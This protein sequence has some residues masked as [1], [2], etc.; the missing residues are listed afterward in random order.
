MSGAEFI[1]ESPVR[2]SQIKAIRTL[3]QGGW[4][5]LHDL[6]QYRVSGKPALGVGGLNPGQLFQPFLQVG[7]GPLRIGF[8]AQERY[9]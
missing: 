3:D 1:Q 8:L 9:R 4:H 7:S 2:V 5:S 6:H